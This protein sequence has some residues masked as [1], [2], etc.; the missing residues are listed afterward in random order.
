MILFVLSIIAALIPW[1]GKYLLIIVIAGMLLGFINAAQG[2]YADVP[3]VGDL[4]KGKLSMGQL[5]SMTG[6]G[7]GKIWDSFSKAFKRGKKDTVSDD[8]TKPSES[9]STP[10]PSLPA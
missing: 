3:F 7:L 6:A 10:P 5:F 4:A 1:I 8:K 9:S 2:R